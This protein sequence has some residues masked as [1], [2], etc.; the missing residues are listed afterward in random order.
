MKSRK[1]STFSYHS[2]LIGEYFFSDPICEYR[3]L[4]FH[5]V[6]N[7]CGIHNEMDRFYL[8]IIHDLCQSTNEINAIIGNTS[9]FCSRCVSEEFL[10]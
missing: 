2:G 1:Y 8:E 10:W 4:F 5:S 7:A 3:H 9:G 6:S